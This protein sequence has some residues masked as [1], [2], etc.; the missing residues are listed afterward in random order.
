MDKLDIYEL[1]DIYDAVTEKRA[2]GMR[3]VLTHIE[4]LKYDMGKGDY[5]PFETVSSRIKT[6]RSAM[7]KCESK[8]IE[9]C[10]E[11]FE[12]MHDIA[13]VRIVVPFLD[14]VDRVR[15]ALT[16]R[17]TLR[18]IEE[19]NYIDNPKPSGYRS[20]HLICETRTSLET[21]FEW[22]VIEIQIRTIFQNAW[23]SLEHKLRY[24]KRNL[25]NGIAFEWAQ[26]GDLFYE[27]D[28]QLMRL[29]DS[30]RARGIST[31]ENMA[32]MMS[33]AT[34]AKALSEVHE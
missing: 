8:G 11:A 25:E 17:D 26:L 30:N 20:L 34:A 7:K 12:E 9:P 18:V 31:D 2:C 13:G 24:K 16:V 28:K 4:N 14:D 32:S 1:E 19:R 27:K 5:S 29:R 21:D 10:E 22:N 3:S 23:C 6:F 33:M 15:N